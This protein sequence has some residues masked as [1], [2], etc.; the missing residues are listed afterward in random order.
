[1][2][3]LR[4]LLGDK[5]DETIEKASRAYIMSFEDGADFWPMWVEFADSDRPDGDE[6]EVYTR[7]IVADTRRDLAAA[8]AAVLPDLLAEAWNEGYAQAVADHLLMYDNSDD[9]PNPYRPETITRDAT[10]APVTPAAPDATN[11]PPDP[12]AAAT[13]PHSPERTTQ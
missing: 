6:G 12:S 8:L 11:P 5:Y 10:D 9:T 1:M 4:A 3:D 7:E 13:G 2:T